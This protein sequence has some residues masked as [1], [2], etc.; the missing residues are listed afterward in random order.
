[1]MCELGAYTMDL[2][3]SVGLK[4]DQSPVGAVALNVLASTGSTVPVIA[5]TM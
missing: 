2:A 5:K 3:L 4:A 1:V